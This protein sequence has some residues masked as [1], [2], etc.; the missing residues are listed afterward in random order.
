MELEGMSQIVICYKITEYEKTN[1]F[2]S[3][4]AGIG[5]RINFRDDYGNDFLWWAG[6]ADGFQQGG[7]YLIDGTIVGYEP[8]NKYTSRPQ[9]RI[10]RVRIVQDLQNPSAPTPT[11]A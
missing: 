9:T 5:Y 11:E 8:V 10:N 6:T 2:G 3:G 1:T 7:K 4:D